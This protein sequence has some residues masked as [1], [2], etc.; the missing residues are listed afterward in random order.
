M[1]NTGR[2]SKDCHLCR[3]RR[4]KCDLGRPGCTRC[5]KYGVECPGY[6][7]LQDLLF[8]NGHPGPSQ[9]KQQARRTRAR[10]GSRGSG[11]P[12]H[13]LGSS[14]TRLSSPGVEE[15]SVTVAPWLGQQLGQ[16]WTAQSVPIIFDICSDVHFLIKEYSRAPATDGPLYWAT[17]LF[18]RAYL[19]NVIQSTAGRA[20]SD[21]ERKRELALYFD[22]TLRSVARELEKPGA[23]FRNDL[24]AA[25]WVFSN[26]E[27]LVG[28]A[29]SQKKSR[30][31]LHT[32]GL[33]S[34]MQA[35][36][37]G[38]LSSRMARFS[39][40]PCFNM[41]Q[42]E[43]LANN[44]EC[45][46]ETESWLA[47]I[48]AAMYPREAYILPASIFITHATRL[49]ARTHG[50]LQ[51]RD[52]DG[53]A[54]ELFSLADELAAAEEEMKRSVAANGR[55]HEAHD[56]DFSIYTLVCSSQI[57]T[58]HSLA[59]LANF[60]RHYA[61]RH[62]HSMDDL[63]GMRQHCLGKMQAAAQRIIDS[64]PRFLGDMSPQAPRGRHLFMASLNIMRP[65]TIVY[66]A[67]SMLPAQGEAARRVLEF[68][69][70]EAGLHQALCE[71]SEL[72]GVSDEAPLDRAQSGGAVESR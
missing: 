32:R 11:L 27:L 19:T 1:P 24:L 8:R 36:G 17:H 67:R 63:D 70:R 35:R 60:V 29:G 51:G 9:K 56:F 71:L 61:Q 14:I 33:Y 34:M 42:V 21:G 10:S 16:H 41:I 6:R 69:A 45:P 23:A 55:S 20:G 47:A 72:V 62:S 58:H 7:D 57:Q 4:V 26:Y 64:I 25:I 15:K 43:A 39:F 2:P 40:W 52:V 50:I 68:M 48:S 18:S 13:G 49:L 30:W 12:D 22:G 3:K 65:I 44:R 66:R 53:A 38:V 28:K 5:V 37:I 31:C 54:R 59:L 46:P